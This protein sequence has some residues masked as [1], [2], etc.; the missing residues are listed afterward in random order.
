M[1]PSSY[2]GDKTH[3]AGEGEGALCGRPLDQS[4]FTGRYEH[5]TCGACWA[6][7]WREVLPEGCR[8]E[9]RER[10]SSRH[11]WGRLNAKRNQVRGM[12]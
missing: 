3:Y 11:A 4:I 8:L 12:E 2:Y 10:L 5:V 9:V 1:T 6:A 7:I